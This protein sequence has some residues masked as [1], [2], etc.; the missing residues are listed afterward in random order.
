MSGERWLP[1][2]GFEGVYEV[3]DL[4][5]VRSFA[6][7]SSGRIRKLSANSQGYV[8]VDL[9]RGNV[10]DT[11]RL[12][13]IVLETFVGPAPEGTEGCHG[14][15]VRLDN[16]L[17]NLR[18]DTRIEN[19]ADIG[20]HGTHNNTAKTECPQGHPFNEENTYVSPR[21]GRGCRECRRASVR[22]HRVKQKKEAS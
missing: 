21:G 17:S 4:G 18:W 20:R 5:R 15:G 11:R 13:R 3:S 12:H 22:A 8:T 16:R 2:A 9:W 1:I 19:M 10:Q 14:N 7:S 6:K